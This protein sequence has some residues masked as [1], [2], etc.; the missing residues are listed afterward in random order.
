MRRKQECPTCEQGGGFPL[1]GGGF[2]RRHFL[3]VAGTG[4]VASYFADVLNPHLLYGATKRASNVALKSSAKR[5]IF[6]F[7]SGA[8]SH[9]DMWDLK[10]GAWTPG[11]SAPATYLDGNLRFPQGL[12]PATAQHLDKMTF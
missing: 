12:M 8:P 1:K 2:S 10:E 3:R 5:C 9:T 6:I 7:L 11:N 4:V